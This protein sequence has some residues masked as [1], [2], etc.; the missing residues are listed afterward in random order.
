M[1]KK[2]CALFA[3]GVLT[4]YL[5]AAS[6][7]NTGTGLF[8]LQTSPTITTPSIAT[9]YGGS[10]AGSTIT[11]QGT[12]NG[13]PS[14]AYTYV[15]PIANNVMI[16]SSN[17]PDGP[18]TISHNA[19]PAAVGP[20]AG[21]YIHI[22]GKDG[23]APSVVMDAF[24]GAGGGT[25]PYMEGRSASGTAASP[26]AITT[27][28]YLYIFGA[29]G[30]DGSSYVNGGEF[31]IQ[32]TQTW[33]TSAHGAKMLI[34]VT[35]NGS[36][37]GANITAANFDQDGQ[38]YFPN[39]V[40]SSSATSGAVCY[41]S[42]NG[43]INYDH[44]TTCLASSAQYKNSISLWTG[45]ALGLIAQM[46]PVTFHYNTNLG[47]GPDMQHLGLIAEDVAK[48][49][50]RLVDNPAAP[51]KINIQDEVAVLVK[52]IQEQ[53]A[54]ITNLQNALI[55]ASIPIP[56]PVVTPPAYTPPTVTPYVPPPP[57]PKTVV[58]PLAQ[59]AG[60]QLA[61]NDSFLNKLWALFHK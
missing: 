58:P 22:I 21:N 7:G 42:S 30:Y 11:I 55:A 32:P 48:V 49:D 43:L 28:N 56:N 14:S 51:N 59:P 17:A 29:Q 8:V 38:V 57:Q 33:T 37:S 50:P 16:G 18:V 25:Y 3:L 45:S 47:M 46:R 27:A 20:G 13:S 44:T 61:Q 24:K 5:F 60:V 53:Q 9:V 26:T 2:I 36:S 54:E 10:A 41:T 19:A 34:V 4:L 6:S 12:S 40:A 15:D 39:L 35:S 1:F 52:A 31:L 23:D